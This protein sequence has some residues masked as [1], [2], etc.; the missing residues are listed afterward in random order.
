MKKFL[1]CAA[2]VAL[3]AACTQ[4]D[5]L[6]NNAPSSQAQGQGLSF[7]VTLADNNIETKGELYEDEGTY[8]FFWYAEQDRINVFGVNLKGA[9]SSGSAGTNTALVGYGS[10]TGGK[11]VAT[12]SFGTWTL[13]SAAASY[14]ATQ[15]KGEGKFTAANDGDMLVFDGEKTS[16]IVATYGDIAATTVESKMNDDNTDIIPGLEGITKLELTTDA[17]KGSNIEQTVKHPNEVIAPMYSVSSAAAEETYHSV[18][19]QANLQL[20]RPFPVIRFTTTGVDKY[21]ED[22]GP[23]ESVSLITRQ[24]NAAG[25]WI[26]A[27]STI[28]YKAG[29]KYTV[30]GDEVGFASGWEFTNNSGASQYK[31]QVTVN[32]TSQEN[33]SDDDAVYMTVAPVD[34]SEL[35]DGDMLV[36]TYQFKNITFTLDGSKENAKEF[37]T[38]I[39]KNSWNATTADGRP[40]AVTPLPALDINNYD[41]LLVGQ[42]GNYTLIINRGS[43]A[44]TINGTNVI[45]PVGGTTGVAISDVKKVIVNCDL[46]DADFANLNKFTAAEHIELTEETSIPTD[47]L[48]AL[49]GSG[50]ALKELVLPKVTTI[51]EDFVDANFETLTK[52]ELGSYP[53]ETMA[54]NNRFFN[55][56]TAGKLTYIDA[57]AVDDFGPIYMGRQA[58]IFQNYNVLDSIKVGNGAEL[59]AHQFDGC[60]KLQK[61]IGSVDLSSNDATHAFKGVKALKEVNVTTDIIPDYAFYQASAIES[62]LKDG[63]QLAPTAVG[64]FAFMEA[65]A[66]KYMDLANTTELGERAFNRSGLIASKKDAD[67]KVGAKVISEAALANTKVT[68]VHF[69]NAESVENQIL[70]GVNT[71]VQIKFNK[72]FKASLP[73]NT[74]MDAQSFGATTNSKNVD[75]L[76]ADGQEY[77]GATITVGGTDFTFKSIRVE[78]AY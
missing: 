27:G 51:A 19:E 78:A 70:S 41:Y 63:N 67:L 14:K 4:E 36:I 35:E 37:E 39:T 71:L 43:I 18:G 7:N 47:G 31:H 76:V 61:V 25:E 62:V 33:W 13:P 56:Q 38:L 68:F 32:L 49:T 9:I 20:I 3:A 29:A 46:E 40:N 1:Y 15:S 66:L 28:A 26:A 74:K 73:A 72:V 34:R 57:A 60:V 11:G 53:F 5:D 58:I 69:T 10:N 16:T 22:F 48:K 12:H 59:Y 44:S 54:I 55:A 45:W 65:V 50:S 2:V 52:L 21:A 23:L 8:P 77:N 30:V 75:L 64:E 6:L 17:T 42:S 24:K